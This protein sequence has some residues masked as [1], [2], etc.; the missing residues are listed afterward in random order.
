MVIDLATIDF[1]PGQGGGPGEDYA[2]KE[3]VQEQGYLSEEDP[4]IAPL[5]EQELVM[6]GNTA[7]FKDVGI[8]QDS[9]R[10]DGFV[11]EI[12]GDIYYNGLDNGQYKLFKFNKEN[13]LFKFVCDSPTPDPMWEDNSGNVHIGNTWL[14]D[15]STGIFTNTELGGNFTYNYN[16]SNIVKIGDLI[17]MIDTYNSIAY[18]FDEGNQTFSNYSVSC[19]CDYENWYQRQLNFNGHIV[20]VR[21]GNMYELVPYFENEGDT[22]PTRLDCVQL[23]VPYYP[24]LGEGLP[25]SSYVAKANDVWY[26]LG[27]SDHT[28]YYLDEQ[29]NQWVQIQ[30]FT[31]PDSY[32]I[33]LNGAYANDDYIFGFGYNDLNKLLIWYFGESQYE[34]QFLV[35]IDEK[36]EEVENKIPADVATQSWVQSQGYA[37]TNDIVLLQNQIVQKA[38]KSDCIL[39]KTITAPYGPHFTIYPNAWATS[40]NHWN[41]WTTPS[42]RAFCTDQYNRIKE[43][44]NDSWVTV[45][46]SIVP[47]G[48]NIYNTGTN[49]FYLDADQQL[50]YLWDDTNS[51]WTSICS[52]PA[53]PWNGEILITTDDTLRC[54]D[55]TKLTYNNGVWSWEQSPMTDQFKGGGCILV[56]STVYVVSLSP[57]SLG[58][59][60]NYLYTYDESTTTYTALGP[61]SSIYF[62]NYSV[63]LFTVNGELLYTGHSS[64]DW[65]QPAVWKWDTALQ[66]EVPTDAYCEG[67]NLPYLAYNNLLWTRQD[68]DDTQNRPWG[69]IAAISESVPEV[70]ASNGTYVLKATRVG[71]QITY[72]WVSAI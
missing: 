44:I 32:T 49:L 56:N 5:L 31:V 13:N 58:E 36:I 7:Q 18:I 43:F 33:S 37:L 1:T 71:D 51:D 11:Y 35:D 42:G 30:D 68:A 41:Y 23:S 14:I 22:Y 21:S 53:N 39:N 3:W 52:T 54:D 57:E 64:I 59:E 24:V 50:T 20:Y 4:V 15:L 55:G 72:T 63:N 27:K 2:T 34:Y 48:S 8:R 19:N 6:E 46:M 66:S 38:D 16:R 61:V 9:D 67:F 69:T 28:I 70:P 17:Y 62:N 12:G 65:E 10:L 47:D 29:Q 45:S 25:T 26:Y 40:A 60:W